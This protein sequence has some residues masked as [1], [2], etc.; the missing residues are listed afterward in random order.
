MFIEFYERGTLGKLAGVTLIPLKAFRLI[1][2]HIGKCTTL[3]VWYTKVVYQGL[4]ITT[5]YFIISP[6]KFKYSKPKKKVVW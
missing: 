1:F 4:S 3:F 5:N 2:S 6:S